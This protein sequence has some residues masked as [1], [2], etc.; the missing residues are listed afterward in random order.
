MNSDLSG[1]ENDRKRSGRS[2]VSFLKTINISLILVLFQAGPSSLS[3]FIPVTLQYG[4]LMYIGQSLCKLQSTCAFWVKV[5]GDSLSETLDEIRK[6]P[7]DR[8]IIRNKRI[9][10]CVFLFFQSLGIRPYVNR[11]QKINLYYFQIKGG[12]LYFLILNDLI[13]KLSIKKI[14]L[15]YDF[16]LLHKDYFIISLATYIEKN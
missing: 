16:S 3:E 11:F 7:Q 8:E 13:K 9:L 5:R 15:L 4:R 14:N 6:K 1:F 12:G 2:S 10:F